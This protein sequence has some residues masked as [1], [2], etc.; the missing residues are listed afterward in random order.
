MSTQSNGQGGSGNG[1]KPV[2]EALSAE[3]EG[4]A[5]VSGRSGAGFAAP[6]YTAAPCSA[7]DQ[8]TGPIVL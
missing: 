5:P 2:V 8:S 4:G 7:L 1:N 3:S 6:W